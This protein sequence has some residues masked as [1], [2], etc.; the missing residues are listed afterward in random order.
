MTFIRRFQLT[1]YHFA[2]FHCIQ[3]DEDLIAPSMAFPNLLRV[4]TDMIDGTPNHLVKGPIC[5]SD[6]EEARQFLLANIHVSD[7]CS[8]EVRLDVDYVPSIS[9]DSLKSFNATATDERCEGG[10]GNHVHQEIFRIDF[11]NG[12]DT[13]GLQ[14]DNTIVRGMGCD[15]RDQNC[16]GV[17][18]DCKSHTAEG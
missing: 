10:N 12:F 15:G 8:H 2:L 11:F 3:G 14:S 16:N 6:I 9:S 4:E 5:F 18:D 13:Q 17:I 7:D 1:N